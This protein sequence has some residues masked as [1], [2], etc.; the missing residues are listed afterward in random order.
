MGTRG[1]FEPGHRFAG[2]FAGQLSQQEAGQQQV[3]STAAT[4][5]HPAVITHVF[6]LS[7][8]LA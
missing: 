1:L 8:S 6:S 2:G 4:S 3:E 7:H 5:F